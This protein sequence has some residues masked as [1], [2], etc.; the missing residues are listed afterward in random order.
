M[1]PL[2]AGLRAT[3]STLAFL[4]L[5]VAAPAAVLATQLDPHQEEADG[6]DH[7]ATGKPCRP[8]PSEHGKD[9]E[10]HG[11]HGGVN[12]DHCLS[13]TTTTIGT[14]TSTTLPTVTTTSTPDAVVTTTATAP[15]S[16]AVETSVPTVGPSETPA[17]ITGQD[18]QVVTPALTELARTGS[19]MAIAWGI[20]I[21]A[22][23]V[24][25][26]F[27]FLHMGRNG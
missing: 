21:G 13:V 20:S 16:K 25:L 11:N 27:A 15:P 6:C 22:M 14:I 9:C 5:F 2:K 12:E 18:S 26:G 3:M 1:N 8:D 7:G 23:L 4:L 19:G 17:T 24:L 10:V